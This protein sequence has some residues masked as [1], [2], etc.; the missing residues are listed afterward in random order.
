MLVLSLLCQGARRVRSVQY[1]CLTGMWTP[2]HSDQQ[3]HRGLGTSQRAA[4]SRTGILYIQRTSLGKDKNKKTNQVYTTLI[5]SVYLFCEIT[6]KCIRVR[7]PDQLAYIVNNM[8]EVC[9]AH[10]AQI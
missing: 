7:P 5:S 10:A 2:Q 9:H 6:P 3:G 4:W 1:N 8:A